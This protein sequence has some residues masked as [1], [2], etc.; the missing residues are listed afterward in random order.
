[1]NVNYW[2][3]VWDRARNLPD[4]LFR[5]NMKTVRIPLV[6]SPH[7]RQSADSDTFPAIS[8]LDQRF[9][10]VIFKRDLN[11]LTG[12]QRLRVCKRPGTDTGTSL[13]GNVSSIYTV[14]WAT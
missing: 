1:M 13:T 3:G 10:N 12:L 9:V 11:P 2:R 4:Y 5:P 6:G 14:G 7:H 8:T